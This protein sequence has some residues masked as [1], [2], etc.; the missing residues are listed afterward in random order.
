MD[1]IS[2]AR[3]VWLIVC[4]LFVVGVSAWICSG[5]PPVTPPAGP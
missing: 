2:P 5:W 1:P 3:R 4:A